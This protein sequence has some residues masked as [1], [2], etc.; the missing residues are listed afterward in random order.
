MW[1]YGVEGFNLCMDAVFYS[2]QDRVRR[3]ASVAFPWRQVSIVVPCQRHALRYDVC[4][5]GF[6]LLHLRREMQGEHF[7]WCRG[8][9][10][11]LDTQG[12]DPRGSGAGRGRRAHV[13]PRRRRRGQRGA[14]DGGAGV[15]DAC[16]RVLVVL[17]LHGHEPGDVGDPLRGVLPEDRD[18][19]GPD[20][21][22]RNG[23]SVAVLRLRAG[24][25]DHGERPADQA[26]VPRGGAAADRGAGLQAHMAAGRGGPVRVLH[27]L[28]DAAGPRHGSADLLEER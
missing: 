16:Q 18:L 11:H 19:L 1:G 8:K 13:P 21:R 27:E 6:D 28:A 9:L 7:E 23:G 5:L 4:E 3:P 25:Q 15:A 14:G 20:G 24:R 26:G 2:L 12:E 22:G 10:L 17:P